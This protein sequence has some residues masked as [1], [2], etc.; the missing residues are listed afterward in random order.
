MYP[1]R[2]SAKSDEERRPATS[3]KEDK[4]VHGKKTS[5][6]L[7]TC[8]ADPDLIHTNHLAFTWAD[9]SVG[10]MLCKVAGSCYLILRNNKHKLHI[11]GTAGMILEEQESS[12]LSFFMRDSHSLLKR[13]WVESWERIIPDYYDSPGWEHGGMTAQ[14]RQFWERWRTQQIRLRVEVSEFTRLLEVVENMG[15]HWDWK[16]CAFPPQN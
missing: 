7:F 1:Y 8:H 12:D 16:D 11:I 6:K 14:L 2:V 15:K 4:D 3:L 5:L 9:V 13:E 10:D